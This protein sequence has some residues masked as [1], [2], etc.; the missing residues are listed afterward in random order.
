[1]EPIASFPEQLPPAHTSSIAFICCVALF[2][3]SPQVDPSG[4]YIEEKVPS[5]QAIH[6]YDLIF[7]MET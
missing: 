2:F 7:G 5:C 1:M 3:I 4:R 6:F